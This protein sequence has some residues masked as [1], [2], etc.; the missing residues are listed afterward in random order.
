[1]FNR[2]LNRLRQM[3]RVDHVSDPFSENI[4]LTFFLRNYN[5][6][7]TWQRKELER[8]KMAYTLNPQRIER[9]NSAVC[10]ALFKRVA[11]LVRPL[12]ASKITVPK[13]TFCS[14]ITSVANPSLLS[15]LH[16]I[17]FY[18]CEYHADYFNIY[19][20]PYWE[21]TILKYKLGR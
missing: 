6:F 18:V 11:N 8:F 5:G 3:L 9:E 19:D 7:K 13:T 12:K 10:D 1:M 2:L 14:C 16:D 4:D 15:Q 20:G 21:D 17:Y